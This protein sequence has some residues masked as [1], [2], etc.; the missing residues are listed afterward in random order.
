M[1]HYR[2]SV[3]ETEE[4]LKFVGIDFH[5]QRDLGTILVL[6]AILLLWFILT[7]CYY[8]FFTWCLMKRG[9]TRQQ[10][11]SSIWQ[12]EAGF[13]FY[14]IGAHTD[15]KTT[16]VSTDHASLTIY[17][18]AYGLLRPI[19]DYV[20]PVICFFSIAERVVRVFLSSRVP[21]TPDHR[22]IAV[23][24]CDSI[25]LRSICSCA[26]SSLSPMSNLTLP[27]HRL[28][29]RRERRGMCSDMLR[30]VKYL[31]MEL[32]LP[33]GSDVQLEI[34]CEEAEFVPCESEIRVRSQLDI[35]YIP[36]YWYGHQ[37]TDI[38]ESLQC[39]ICLSLLRQP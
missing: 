22:R 20:L 39:H 28:E 29:V 9:R 32:P 33:E 17:V 4:A 23:H 30:Q 27:Q 13:V 36:A 10:A 37:C 19:F 3:S 5:I 31:A 35:R 24:L 15:T 26:P 2:V 16:H 6:W 34:P 12:F 25:H 21:A 7:D 14:L 1:R 18:P 38:K 8:R 11:K